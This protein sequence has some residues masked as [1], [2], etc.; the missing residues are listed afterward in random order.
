MAKLA[1][2]GHSVD[3]TSNAATQL[4]D[5]PGLL[6]VYFT[7]RSLQL[8]TLSHFFCSTESKSSNET[9]FPRRAAIHGMAGIGKTQTALK[10]ADMF[11]TNFSTVLWAS[12]AN[13][14]KLAQSYDRFAELLDLPEK[15]RTEQ[16][17]RVNAVKRW[18]SRDTRNPNGYSWLLIMDNVHKSN[19]QDLFEFLPHNNST[20]GSI[21]FTTRWHE[22][23]ARL[24]GSAGLSIEL[25]KMN[26]SEAVELLLSAAEVKDRSME[27]KAKALNVAVSIGYLPLVLDQLGFVAREAEGDLETCVTYVE[28]SNKSMVRT[29]RFEL[30]VGYIDM[31]HRCLN[32]RSSIRL[33]TKP[34][35]PRLLKRF[36]RSLKKTSRMQRGYLL[37]YLFLIPSTS[38][39]IS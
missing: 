29:R 33:I 21:L 22:V 10:F 5:V 9:G 15:T 11:R 7:G 6:S 18:F 1:P 20:G 19:I 12:A 31:G 34:Q 8:T 32:T 26:G 3:S 28:E 30:I 25:T 35:W 27:A 14:I 39:R 16:H 38:R 24:V 17:V 13:G 4:F 37:C 23:A 36:S 2:L